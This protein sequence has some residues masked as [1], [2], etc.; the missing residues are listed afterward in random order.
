MLRAQR[1]RVG[2]LPPLDH[3]RMHPQQP[4]PY[5]EGADE[6]SPMKAQDEEESP[7]GAEMEEDGGEMQQEMDMDQQMEDE[8]SPERDN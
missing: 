2:K 6:G 1:P 3:Q 7:G 5:D 4:P 8:G